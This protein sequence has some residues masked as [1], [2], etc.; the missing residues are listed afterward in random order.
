M[1]AGHALNPVDPVE[2]KFLE[3]VHVPDDNLDLV[4]GVL[5]GNQETLLDLRE[6]VDFVLEMLEASGV[7]LSIEI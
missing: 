3:G 1:N 5:P 2:Q 4:V 6:L 7:C